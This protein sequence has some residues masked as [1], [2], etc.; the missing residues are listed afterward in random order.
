L[1][2]AD[3]VFKTVDAM[4]FYPTGGTSGAIGSKGIR[5]DVS[6]DGSVPTAYENRPVSISVQYYITY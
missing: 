2:Y 5:F 6:N 1:I 4:Q 3:G